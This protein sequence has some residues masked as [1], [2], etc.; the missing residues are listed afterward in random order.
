MKSYQTSVSFVNIFTVTFVLYT[1]PQYF[2][3][4]LREIL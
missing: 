3:T 4:D 1:N 2:L